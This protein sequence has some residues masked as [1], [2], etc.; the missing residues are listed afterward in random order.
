ML[1]RLTA[2]TF[3]LA[4]AAGTAAGAPLHYGGHDCPMA[5]MEGMDCCEKAR[6]RENSPEVLA[7]RLCCA[8]S[9]PQP[10]PVNTTNVGPVQ[11]PSADTPHPAAAPSQARVLPAVCELSLS[12]TP[13]SESPP[14]YIRHSSLLI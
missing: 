4:L 13:P 8:F 2:L 6:A 5:G 11:A 7:A 3:I 10:A 1:R 9:C 12:R 14:G